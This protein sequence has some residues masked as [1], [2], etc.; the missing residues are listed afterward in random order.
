MTPLLVAIDRGFSTVLTLLHILMVLITHT[1]LGAEKSPVE[2]WLLLRNDTP[3]IVG[4]DLSPFM[5]RHY[6]VIVCGATLNID[7]I[8][9]GCVNTALETDT[10]VH[11]LLVSE[12]YRSHRLTLDDTA[13]HVARRQQE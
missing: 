13:W 11:V 9:P 10:A 6:F 7:I 5:H 4:S 12:G 1:L 8:K 2:L 3:C